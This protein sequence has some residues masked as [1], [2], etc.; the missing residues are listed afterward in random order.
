MRY[1]VK[2]GDKPYFRTNDKQSALAAVSK[3]F[4]KGHEDIYL[5][6]G[7]IGKWWSE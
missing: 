4:N 1:Q 2:I 7:R 3:L 5:H 6:G